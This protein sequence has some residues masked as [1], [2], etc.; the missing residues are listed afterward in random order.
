MLNAET[1]DIFATVALPMLKTKSKVLQKI[2]KI[3]FLKAE[4]LY[5][6][7]CCDYMSKVFSHK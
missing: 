6:D 4:F 1:C 7:H 2:Q 3:E 5:N